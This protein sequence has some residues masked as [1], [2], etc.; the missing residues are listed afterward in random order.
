M[1]FRMSC[2]F[3]FIIILIFLPFYYENDTKNVFANSWCFLYSQLQ[4]IPFRV[5]MGHHSKTRTN[6]LTTCTLTY[7]FLLFVF[8]VIVSKW[9]GM[10]FSWGREDQDSLLFTYNMW[11]VKDIIIYHLVFLYEY[12]R[13][14][15][16]NIQLLNIFW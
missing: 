8:I 11:N 10:S 12:L 9:M 15:D 5:F 16:G 4:D 1:Q 13:K 6:S 2:S 7:G 14:I 3:P